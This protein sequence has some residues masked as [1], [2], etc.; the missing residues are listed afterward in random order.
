MSFISSHPC[1]VRRHLL[2]AKREVECTLQGYLTYKKCSPLGPYRRPVP[3]VL[4]GWEFS[5]GRGTPLN[6]ILGR[7]NA[8]SRSKSSAPCEERGRVHLPGLL[9][10][11]G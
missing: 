7:M 2:S 6:Q 8:V 11:F 3:R 4:G 9:P 5:Y 10:D 1:T